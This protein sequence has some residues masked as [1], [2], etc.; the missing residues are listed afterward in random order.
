MKNVGSAPAGGWLR[1]SRTAGA[2]HRRSH[3]TRHCLDVASVRL[4]PAAV[5]AD[6][7]TAP[8][9]PTPPLQHQ[10]LDPPPVPCRRPDLPAAAPPRRHRPRSTSTPLDRIHR[11][12]LRLDVASLDR[13]TTSPEG[14]ADQIRHQHGASRT[15]R[16][17]DGGRRGGDGGGRDVGSPGE[18]TTGVGG[19]ATVGVET[20]GAREGAA[21][22]DGDRRRWRRV[23]RRRARGKGRRPATGAEGNRAA[24][25]EGTAAR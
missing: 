24:E 20:W 5:R 12:L 9:P 4:A 25:R 3:H 21:A 17:D 13:Q 22:K 7:S 18:R 14:G 23:R 1:S 8:P 15:G 2:R 19:A 16:A 10:R 11:P 6:A